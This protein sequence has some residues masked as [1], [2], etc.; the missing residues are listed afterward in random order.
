MVM[1]EWYDLMVGGG[2]GRNGIEFRSILRSECREGLL[3]TITGTSSQLWLGTVD[4]IVREPGHFGDED[5][6]A[7]MLRRWLVWAKN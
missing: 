1:S 6:Y 4:T 5:Y 3:C 7:A 2:G